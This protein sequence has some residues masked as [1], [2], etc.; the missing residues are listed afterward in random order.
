MATS[1][2]ETQSISGKVL[3]VRTRRAWV[4][5]IL[6][7]IIPGS[8][9][10][11]HGLGK[12]RRLGRFALKLWSVLVLL[13]I[14][15][16]VCFFVIRNQTIG[17]FTTGVVLKILG[18]LV[19]LIGVFWA[20][21]ALDT[22]VMA[23]PRLLGAAKGAVFTI[24]SLLLAAAL[25]F[26]TVWVGHTMW[27]AGGSLASIF[28]GGGD[29][30]Q[31]EGRYNILLLGTDAGPDRWGL[32]P[33]SIMVASVSASTG[34]AVLISLPRN[35]ENVPFPE[36][37]PLHALYPSGYGCASHECM[38][39]AVYLLGT[40][41]ADLYPGVDDPGI[42]ATIDAVTGVTGLSINYYAMVNMEGFVEL[43]DAMGGITLTAHKRILID[44]KTNQW[45][46][47]GQQHLDGFHALWFARSRYGN[48]DY[49]RMARQKCVMA[50]ILQQLDAGTVATKFADLASA[51]GNILRTS[52]PSSE[53]GTLTS[54]ALKTKNLPIISL[55]FTPPLIHTGIIQE[56]ISFFQWGGRMTQGMFMK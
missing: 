54:L 44:E 18:V 56:T 15:A 1:V 37:S 29:S 7:L 48:S 4:L 17:F 36:T 41:H 8:A 27:V 32:R 5:M 43:I 13:A 46:E 45:I 10:A 33:D 12:N 3:T 26:G 2:S 21:L 55:S 25:T 52:V 50:A 22:I 28:S 42:Q 40:E 9:Q 49:D 53:I 20:V 16:I 39:N 34:R 51:S 6:G 11:V 19:T 38:I 31:K 14:I 30:S 24:V 23:R 47:V 35:L